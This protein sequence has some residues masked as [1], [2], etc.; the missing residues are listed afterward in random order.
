MNRF[1][2]AAGAEIHVYSFGVSVVKMCIRAVWCRR[3]SRVPPPL[4]AVCVRLGALEVGAVCRIP[5]NR[6]IGGIPLVAFQPN[7]KVAV[8]QLPANNFG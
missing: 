4:A 7:Q 2:G 3:Q 5:R 8:T 1:V 6:G